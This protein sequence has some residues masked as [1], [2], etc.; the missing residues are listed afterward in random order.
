LFV[1]S[2][3]Q[4]KGIS[5]LFTAAREAGRAIE[6]TV[7]GTKPAEPCPALE[8]ALAGINWIPSLPHSGILEHMRR[9]DV[10]VFPS[11][12]EGFGLVILEAMAQGVPVIATPH[13]AAPDIITDGVD[14]FIVPIRDASAIAA[15]LVDLY[16]D[17]ERLL[18]M[19]MAA[20]AKA[21]TFT[22]AS[23]E[24]ALARVVAS[25]LSARRKVRPK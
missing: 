3:G 18:A 4:R 24:N 23:Y 8:N 21:S 22:W 16:H 10:L 2:L 15:R 9:S 17:R 20:R 7:I 19:G 14:G 6:L 25:A 5:Y 1:G 12:F 13:T 11:L